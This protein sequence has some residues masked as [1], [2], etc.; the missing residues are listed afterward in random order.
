MFMKY[1]VCFEK[2]GI[3]KYISHLDF[4]RTISRAIRRA[5]LPLSYSQG[6]NPHPKLSFA[7]PLPVG[8][9]SECEMFEAELEFEVNE[10]IFLEKLNNALPS[11][12]RIKR[13]KAD[14]LKN[15]PVNAAL[16]YIKC[17]TAPS[18]EYLNLFIEVIY[19]IV[20]KSVFVNSFLNF[21]SFFL[22]KFLLAKI[23]L[24]TYSP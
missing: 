18:A 1:V 23:F 11:C 12:I 4:Q 17:E 9:S 19:I 20:T 13:V 8:S 22:K 3:A 6:F 7:A 21:F 24:F 2:K 15:N 14:S 5:R 10:N 16:Y